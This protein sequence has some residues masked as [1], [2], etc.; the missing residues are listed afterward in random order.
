MFGKPTAAPNCC[1]STPTEAALI[2]DD[3]VKLIQLFKNLYIQIKAVP[4]FM[5]NEVEAFTLAS[6]PVWSSKRLCK[7]KPSGR[8]SSG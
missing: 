5:I 1:S 3:R 8:R 6:V 2:K 7:P 4:R